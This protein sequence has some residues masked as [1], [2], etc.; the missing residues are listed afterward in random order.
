MNPFAGL[1]RSRKF[2]L[3]MLD[4]GISLAT[5]FI[6][7]YAAPALADDALF[8]IGSIQPAFVVIIGAIAYEDGKAKEAGNHISQ[9]Q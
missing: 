5:Y 3:L 7:K 4:M 2:W 9:Q 1:L 8:V 6:T